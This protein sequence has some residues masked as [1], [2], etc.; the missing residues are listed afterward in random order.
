MPWLFKRCNHP[1]CE[2]R[3]TESKESL[4]KKHRKQ[5][6]VEYDSTRRDPSMVRFYHSQ[7][8]KN[9]RQM[10]LN[11]HPLCEQCLKQERIEG[12]ITV[13]HIIPIRN[14]GARLDSMNLQSLCASCHGK[15]HPYGKNVEP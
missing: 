4:C 3:F 11:G 12:A 13:D 1:G 15:K 9:A 8:W 6:Q 2:E 5:K 10:H 7:T 14:G